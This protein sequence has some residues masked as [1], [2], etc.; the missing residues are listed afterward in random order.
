MAA[1][2]RNDRQGAGSDPESRSSTIWLGADERGEFKKELGALMDLVEADRKA[3]ETNRKEPVRF[4][5]LSP[6]KH[7]DLRRPSSPDPPAFRMLRALSVGLPIHLITIA[8]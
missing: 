7:E 5:L 4:V 8:A 2:C 6:I 3:D 1:S